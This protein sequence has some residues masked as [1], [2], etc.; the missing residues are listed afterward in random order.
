MAATHSTAKE[1]LFEES[2]LE[3]KD[4]FSRFSLRFLKVEGVE[5]FWVHSCFSIF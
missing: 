1:S 2:L 5:R 3:N 4:S